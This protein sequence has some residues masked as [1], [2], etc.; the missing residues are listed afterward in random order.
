[1]NGALEGLMR[2]LGR[3]ETRWSL[4]WEDNV[5]GFSLVFLEHKESP[6]N[7][8][9]IELLLDLSI[10]QDCELSREQPKEGARDR[11]RESCCGV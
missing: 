8:D 10:Y 1:M 6:R 2:S 4:G 9:V 11:E 3:L 5:N 7:R